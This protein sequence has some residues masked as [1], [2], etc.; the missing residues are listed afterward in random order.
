MTPSEAED[1]ASNVEGHGQ[2]C[3]PSVC[4]EESVEVKTF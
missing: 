1:R 3:F 4:I 2:D